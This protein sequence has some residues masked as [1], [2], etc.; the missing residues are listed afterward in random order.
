MN[1]AMRE[2]G[3]SPTVPQPVR[4]YVGPA[5]RRPLTSVG[6]YDLLEELA[7]GGM[8]VVYKARQ[9]SLGRVVALK[10]IRG[11][12]LA[13]PGDIQRFRSEAEAAA[14]LDHPHIVPIYDV[15]EHDGQPYFSMKLIEGDSLAQ[16]LAE[17]SPEKTRDLVGLL[18]T[19]ARA[20]HYA[21][22]RGLL[23]RD[24]KP[25]N[26]LIDADG[27]P[28]VTD[29]GLA[30]RLGAGPGLT[31][32]GVVVGTPNY[33][34]PEQADGRRPLTTAADVYALGAILYEILTGSPPFA[35]ATTSATLLQVLQSEPAP[36]HAIDPAVDRELETVCLKCLDK[37]PAKRYGSAEALADDLGRW[38]RGEPILAQPR[39]P[40]QRGLR[41]A[42]RR[43]ALAAALS[44]LVV[45]TVVGVSSVVVLW[46]EAEG[47]GE[48]ARRTAYR[49]GVALA[50]AEWREGEAGRAERL[51]AETDAELRGWEWHYLRRLF[52]AHQLR[53]LHGHTDAVNGVAFSPDG[54]RVASA[55]VDGTVRVWESATGRELLSL[56]SHHEAVT[57]VAFDPA[58]TRLVSVG[59][60]HRVHLWQAISGESIAIF[61]RSPFEPLAVAFSPDGRLIASAGGDGLRG[62]LTLW[63]AATGAVV[64]RAG[65]EHPLTGVAF[66]PDGHR[67]YAAARDTKVTIWELPALR[68]AGAL[69][70]GESV[71][72]VACTADGKHVAAARANGAVR[73]WDAER[74][75]ELLL[76]ET[77][78]GEPLQ[79]VALTSGPRPFVFAAGDDHLIHGWHLVTGRHL[80][81]FRGHDG[82]VRALAFSAD[83]TRLASASADRTIKLWEV[84]GTPHDELT[85]SDGSYALK[86]VVF[87]PDGSRL[88]LA[89]EST[90]V[91]VWDAADGRN[92]LGLK[93]H[94]SQVTAVAYSPDGRQIASAGADA[95]V[96]VWDSATGAEVAVLRGHAGCVTA[97]AFS[98]DG[99]QIISAGADGTVRLWDVAERREVLCLS[100]HDG[101][102]HGVA[103]SPGGR[104]ASAG[105][106]GTVRLWDSA[107]GRL[108]RMLTGHAGAV[109]A[110]AFSPD[111]R[112]LASAASDGTVRI[113]DAARGREVWCLRGH[114]GAVHGVAF[115]PGGRLASGGA[116]RAVKL[117]D[118]ASGQELLTLRGHAGTIQ[119]LAFSRDGHRLASV[120]DDRMLKVWDG[121]PLGREPD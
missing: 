111:G 120:D 7:H 21:H 108:V 6:D 92:L 45:I 8:G 88:V 5:A 102:V 105:A 85:R 71:L 11:G 18:A 17:R 61:Q 44:L 31:P 39:T 51:L 53:T 26:I 33:M 107:T 77:P 41:W 74:G 116:D 54:Q 43:P 73:T 70:A 100:G 38:L 2:D 93:G 114:T 19:A 64:A 101:E 28:H 22:Q 25:D 67:L 63:D 86:G 52:R 75:N 97:V 50:R 69:S 62:E 99:R 109:R 95:T 113:W 76:V 29:F 48:K 57:A 16:R 40:W 83:G 36:P 58:G 49:L 30:K 110:V 104:L 82:P 87:S 37:D 1:P 20:V 68:P 27:R 56:G 32:S 72:A 94:G 14:Q 106:D 46:R 103:V 24:L 89:S 90:T 98:S 55:G 91:K 60:D 65:Q 15:G 117:W 3:P 112:D 10:M 59:A 78:K 115:G 81:T 9:R 23:H 47:S 34:A 84:G 96:R 35:E 118:T 12:R 119:G 13:Q 4:A 80:F 79:A 42:R 121:T 66:A